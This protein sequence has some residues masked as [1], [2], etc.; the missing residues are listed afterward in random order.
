MRKEMIIQRLKER[1]C[2]I[3]KQRLLLLDII[4]EEDCCCCK[5]IY[6]KASKKDQNIGSGHCVSYDQ[7]TGGDRCDH[8]KKYLY[9][10]SSTGRRKNSRLK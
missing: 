9:G 7:Y 6:Y 1:G 2:R 5:E 4:L 10:Q 3:T 8:K